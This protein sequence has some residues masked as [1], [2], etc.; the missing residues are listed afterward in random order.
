MIA[1]FT[2]GPWRV[3]T[4]C[5]DFVMAG[6]DRPG[7]EGFCVCQALGPLVG[8]PEYEANA[9]LIAAAPDGHSFVAAIT[10]R[11]GYAEWASPREA[12]EI[13]QEIIDEFHPLGTAY[14]LKVR[15]AS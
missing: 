4:H 10:E 13:L 11:L 3:A 12:E 1:G 7:A 15:D 5:C 6:G 9:R 14:L 2:P 8:R